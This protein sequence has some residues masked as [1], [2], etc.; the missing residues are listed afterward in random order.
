MDFKYY[1]PH[2]WEDQETATWEDVWILP[3]DP[4]YNGESLWFTLDARAD[5][6]WRMLPEEQ[7]DMSDEVFNKLN[8]S[9]DDCW[10][11]DEE[12]KWDKDGCHYDDNLANMSINKLRFKKDDLLFYLRKWLIREFGDCTLL[13]EG[14]YEDFSD[15]NDHAR[16]MKGVADIKEK[17]DNGEIE[18]KIV[19]KFEDKDNEEYKKYVKEVEQDLGHIAYDKGK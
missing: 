5:G 9:A 10:G 6:Y 11:E 7:G 13:I 17:V 19:D 8:K 1:I 14:T 2:R 4:D 15:T 18:L 12:P 16:M 3:L